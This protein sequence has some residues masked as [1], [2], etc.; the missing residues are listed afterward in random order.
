MKSITT[1]LLLAISPLFAVDYRT[2]EADALQK[3]PALQSAKLE[4]D[5]A[6]LEGAMALRYDNPSLEMEASRFDADNG[7]RATVSQSLR[8]FGLGDDLR[9]H[10]DSL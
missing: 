2:F 8:V 10:A 4:S 5:A 7:W 9:L 6:R 3:A 1:F